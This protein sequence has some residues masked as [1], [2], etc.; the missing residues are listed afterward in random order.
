MT[1]F[2][3]SYQI[4]QQSNGLNQVTVMGD[5]ACWYRATLVSLAL[6]GTP[7]V[8]EINHLQLRMK[9]VDYA[10]RYLNDNLFVG[11][12][13]NKYEWCQNQRLATSWACEIAQCATAALLGITIRVHVGK[14][15]NVYNRGCMI[16]IDILH[17]GMNGMFY[18][19]DA[20]TSM[21]KQN[22]RNV[23]H[24]FDMEMLNLLSPFDFSRAI[25]E[26]KN[27]IVRR[28]LANMYF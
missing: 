28:S 8:H 17:V 20:L 26:W 10:N 12:F 6:A 27:F 1:R 4:R 13:A 9:V 23:L 24:Q 3:R 21:S 14:S 2:V 11:N 5:G 25:I 15:I 18:H 16:S 22:I 7:F 19:F